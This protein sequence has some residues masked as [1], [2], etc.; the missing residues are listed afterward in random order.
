MVRV[1]DG[2]EIVRGPYRRKRDAE[3]ERAGHHELICIRAPR[4]KQYAHHWMSWRVPGQK[5][6]THT[7]KNL[8]RRPTKE[9]R[10]ERMKQIGESTR[11]RRES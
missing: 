9:E 8:Y 5:A 3:K 11:F 10:R 1:D 7:G 6:V 2:Y 4:G